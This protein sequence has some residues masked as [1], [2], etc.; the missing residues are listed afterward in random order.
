MLINVL[1]S[2]FKTFNNT[3]KS[4]N[5]FLDFIHHW[6]FSDAWLCRTIMIHITMPTKDHSA[7]LH[8]LARN[9][10]CHDMAGI[11][12]WNPASMGG[13]KIP[14]QTPTQIII[15][16]TYNFYLS[17]FCFLNHFFQ[18]L[19]KTLLILIFLLSTLPHVC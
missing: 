15:I 4:M 9:Q 1:W 14:A 12:A 5:I 19:L 17:R 16:P 3:D 11:G 6:P 8:T 7:M 10:Y 2:A 13:T 18:A